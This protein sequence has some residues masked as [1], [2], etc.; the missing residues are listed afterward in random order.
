MK[1]KVNGY[2]KPKP[3]ARPGGGMKG[4][5]RVAEQRIGTPGRSPRKR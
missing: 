1:P 3:A 5:K 2:S 4:V